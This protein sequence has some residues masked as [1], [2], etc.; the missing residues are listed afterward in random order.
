MGT[1]HEL[2]GRLQDSKEALPGQQ[3]I[4]SQVKVCAYTRRFVQVVLRWALQSSVGCPCA[5]L[6]NLYYS[7]SIKRSQIV[8]S[9]FR[10][11]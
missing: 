11:R 10:L 6:I 9:L 2:E 4:E 5:L 1:V 7:P 8:S 3:D